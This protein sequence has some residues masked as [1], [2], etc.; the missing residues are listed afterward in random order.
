MTLM[1]DEIYGVYPKH[2]MMMVTM[3]M[4]TKSLNVA[5]DSKGKKSL[6]IPSF[7]EVMLFD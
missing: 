6:L 1:E 3:T 4:I 5:G 2:A 7:L